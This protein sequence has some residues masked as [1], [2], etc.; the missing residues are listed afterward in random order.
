[1]QKDTPKRATKS[2][3]RRTSSRAKAWKQAMCYSDLQYRAPIF[4]M[5][6]STYLIDHL[7]YRIFFIHIIRASEKR[8][9][10]Q[11]PE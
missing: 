6:E 11:D 10:I 8:V 3:Y 5:Y 1:M 9:M 2:G 7:H 4:L